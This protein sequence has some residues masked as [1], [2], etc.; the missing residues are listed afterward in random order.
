MKMLSRDV[1]GVLCLAIL[2]VN[3][4]LI[5][6]AAAQRVAALLRRRAEIGRPVRGRVVEA[7]GGAIAVHRVDQV[8]R[9]A[10]DDASILFHDRGYAGEATGGTIALD[11]GG[12]ARVPARSEAEVWLRPDEVARAAACPSAEAFDRALEPARKARGFSRTIAA[13][14]G[15]G[16]TVWVAGVVRGEGDARVIEP[17]P[18][19]PLLLA[20]L[21][22]RALLARK[23][24][25][26]AAFAA[27]EIL[28]AAACTAVALW[29]PV[30]GTVSTVGGAL[31]LGFFLLVQPAGVAVR[32]AVLVPARAIVRG[33]WVRP[34]T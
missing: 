19:R 2:W 22:P 20:T 32:D 16:A 17:P 34:A 31:C 7:A 6:G 5:A 15:E 1:M 24:A 27:G 9:A 8:G 33:R 23:A 26:A 28:L 21:D 30:F 18:G 11:G 14:I 3:T 12:E 13:S 29:P 4:L 25:L 10:A